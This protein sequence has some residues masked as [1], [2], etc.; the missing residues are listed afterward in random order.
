MVT[1]AGVPPAETAVFA[2]KDGAVPA[3][4]TPL[5]YD[6]FST[7]DFYKDRDLWFDNRY[8]RCN[9]PVGLEQ[10]WGAYKSPMVGDDP[11]RTAAWGFCNRDYPRKEIVSPYA[12]KT[13]KEHYTALMKEARS[14]GGPTVYTQ[15]RTRQDQDG[16]VV[17]RR[18]AA[19]PDVSIATHTRV[20]TALCPTDVS[21]LG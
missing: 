13:A 21:L 14:R 9:S 2:A 11:P 7:K 6:I 18:G 20:P 8:Y 10:K 15:V 19:N 16:H 1:G 4:V 5:P 17:L 3:G 12:F